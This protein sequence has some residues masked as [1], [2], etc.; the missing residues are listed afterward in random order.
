MDPRKGR[1]LPPLL[2]YNDYMT[3]LTSEFVEGMFYA[4]CQK[5]ATNADVASIMSHATSIKDAVHIIR[6]HPKAEGFFNPFHGI[7]CNWMDHLLCVGE[8][9]KLFQALLLAYAGIN[10]FVDVTGNEQWYPDILP[11]GV[12][13]YQATIKNDERNMPEPVEAAVKAVLEPLADNQRVYLHCQSGLCRSAII[14][15]VVTAV[16]KK[17]PYSE[18]IKVVKIRR[19]V[20]QPQADLLTRTDAEMVIKRL[21]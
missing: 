3:Q 8:E 5:Q 6:K 10:R 13:Y 9:P 11:D 14:A 20:A 21:I 7:S 19:P 15:S 18:A 16:R 17:I 4:I 2:F 12:A 1:R